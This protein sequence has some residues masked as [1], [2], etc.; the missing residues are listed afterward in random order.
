MGAEARSWPQLYFKLALVAP[1]VGRLKRQK[2]GADGA[3]QGEMNHATLGKLGMM[4]QRKKKT[5]NKTYI[6]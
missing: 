2:K 4:G 6:V 1:E 3:K 5:H